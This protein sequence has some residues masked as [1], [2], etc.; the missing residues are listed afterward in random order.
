MKILPCST[1]GFKGAMLPKSAAYPNGE[2]HL[3]GAYVGKY[4]CARCGRLQ[5]LTMAE[6]NAIP[7][8]TIED[9]ERL[10]GDPRDAKRYKPALAAL[11]TKDLE[12]AGFSKDQARDLFRAGFQGPDL[13]ALRR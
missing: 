7:D 13:E 5:T 9:F 11:P 10:A 8:L 3:S 2:P 1:C 4:P 12:G 6:W